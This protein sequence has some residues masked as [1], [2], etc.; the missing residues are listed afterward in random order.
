MSLT[1]TFS[2]I[3]P[4]KTSIVELP[5]RA[6]VRICTM[7]MTEQTVVRRPRVKTQTRTT[8][9]RKLMFSFNSSG[10]GRTKMI[11]SKNMVTAAK[12]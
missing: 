8:F 6:I 2:S 4:H 12:P 11:T 3:T 5:V 1:P 7:R 10:I 9:F